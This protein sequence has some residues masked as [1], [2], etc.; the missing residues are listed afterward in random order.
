MAAMTHVAMTY[1]VRSPGYAFPLPGPGPGP[2][3]P[4]AISSSVKLERE[5]ITR[6]G[7]YATVKINFKKS[8]IFLSKVQRYAEIQRHEKRNGKEYI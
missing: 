5:N 2:N 1:G 8:E 7:L 4:P 3:P 6:N